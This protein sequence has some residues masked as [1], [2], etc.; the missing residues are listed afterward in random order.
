M[1]MFVC[2]SVYASIAR[3]LIR[4]TSLTFLCMLIVLFRRRCDML[5]LYTSGFVDDVMFLHNALYG[6]LCVFMSVDDTAL[7]TVS[8]PAKFCLPIGL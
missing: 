6:A 8:I 5:Q 3:K 2:L 4:Q 1:S 7:T